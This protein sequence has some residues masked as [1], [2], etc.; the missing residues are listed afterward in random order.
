MRGGLYMCGYEIYCGHQGWG[1]TNSSLK[2]KTT[3]KPGSDKGGQLVFMT[4]V[5]R[6]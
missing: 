2:V 1:D 4:G 3:K 5:Y 6:V